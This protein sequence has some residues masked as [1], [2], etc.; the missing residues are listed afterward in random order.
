MG[1]GG[2]DCIA[3]GNMVLLVAPDTN[4]WGML[5]LALTL[6]FGMARRKVDYEMHCGTDIQIE[7]AQ[8]RRHVARDGE[9]DKMHGPFRLTLSQKTLEILVPHSLKDHIR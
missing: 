7:M 5:K 6:A 9:L 1:L 2:A 4:R 8:K 3:D